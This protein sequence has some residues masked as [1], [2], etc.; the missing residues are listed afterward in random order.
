M[1]DFETDIA[2]PVSGFTGTVNAV[3]FEDGA[4]N[5]VLFGREDSGKPAVLKVR[6]AAHQDPIAF[7]HGRSVRVTE[8]VGKMGRELMLAF[9]AT[10]P[11]NIQN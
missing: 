9:P 11:S 8:M 2:T 10:P 7:Y 5:V 3:L 6:L 1:P 4:D